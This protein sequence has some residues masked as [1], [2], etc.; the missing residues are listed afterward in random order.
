MPLD[1]LADGVYVK[2]HLL[3]VSIHTFGLKTPPAPLSL[4]EMIPAIDED[5]F[6]VSVTAA[7]TVIELPGVNIVE[8]GVTVMVVASVAFVDIGD[9]DI[10]DVAE[11]LE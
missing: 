11:L 9:V 3:F 10:F 4:H 8:L 6:E 1:M 7:V 5:R 2:A